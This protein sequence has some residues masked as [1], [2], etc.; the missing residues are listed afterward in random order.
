MV[1]SYFNDRI[2]KYDT[3]EGP[4][5]YLVAGGVP[6]V[7]VLG[8]LLWIIMYDGLLQFKLPRAVTPVAFA[9]YVALVMVGKHLE[10]LS[11]LFSVSFKKYQE[12]LDFTGLELADYKTEAVLITGTK[13]VETITLRVGQHII[14]SQPGLRFLGVMI[15]ARLNFKQQVE[16]AVTKASAVRTVL[17][18]L[19][20]NVGGPKQNRRALLA[21]VVSSITY[22]IDIWAGP[23]QTQETRR[24]VTSVCRLSALRVASA[25]RTVSQEASAVIAC[26]LSIEELADERKRLYRRGKSANTNAELI[27]DEERQSSLLPWQE[28]W[29][30]ADKGR[31]T[32][33]L[34]PHLDKWI[35]RRRGSVNYYLTQ[36]LSRHGC[37]PAYLYKYKYED[38]PE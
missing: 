21:S 14:T 35:N 38:S 27:K 5:E 31:W 19:M 10:D 15:E 25:Y 9:D 33:S 13:V 28:G 24:N 2:L 11:N 23:L 16:H 4:K 29:D 30:K 17:S 26:L 32:Y 6:Q 3:E 1:A 34:I 18:R 36:M 37:F 7:S 12:Y 20:P 8:P 22:G